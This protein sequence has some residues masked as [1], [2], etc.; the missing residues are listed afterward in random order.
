MVLV[1]LW[2]KFS[3]AVV[4]GIEGS[5][6]MFNVR[7]ASKVVRVAFTVVSS[8]CYLVA[9]ASTLKFAVSNNGLKR[10]DSVVMYVCVLTVRDLLVC[11]SEV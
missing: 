6:S 11:F 2:S 5:S 7:S 3:N 8:S 10:G 4:C 9:S 1:L